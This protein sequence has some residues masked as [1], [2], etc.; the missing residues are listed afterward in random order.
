MKT[1]FEELLFKAD[2]TVSQAAASLGYSESHIYRWIRG[3]EMP[4]KGIVRALELE[5]EAKRKTAGPARFTFVDLFAGIGGLRRS[6]SECGG[7]CIFT[8]EWDRFA[9]QTYM[10]NFP[11]NR[12]MLGDIAA[13]DAADIPEHDILSAGFPC[14]PF[15]LAGVSK[16]NSLGR[17]HGFL[18]ETQG[19]L[20]FDWSSLKANHKEPVRELEDHLFSYFFYVDF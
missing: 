11:D 8:S 12:P 18:D 16:K 19:T 2:Y 17:K 20:F 3:E 10:A 5:I 1:K 13:V 9:Q 7:T 4:R 15:S 6:L 14:Q